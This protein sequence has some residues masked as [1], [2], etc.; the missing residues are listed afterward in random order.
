M[1]TSVEAHATRVGVELLEAG[2]NAIDAAVGV[3]FALAVTHPSAGNIGGGGFMLVRMREQRTVAVDFRE[4]APQGLTQPKFDQMIRERARGPAASG[5]PG[6]VSGLLRAHERWGRLDRARVLAPAIRLAREGHVLG[7]RQGL[8]L[9]WAWP[10]L[11]R[12]ASAAAIFG[13]NGRALRR[14]ER[15]VQADLAKTLQRIAEQGSDGFYRGPTAAAFE[16]LAHRGGMLRSADLAG[17]QA[18]WREPLVTNYRGYTVEVMSP[19]SAGGV[20]VVQMLAMLQAEDAHRWEAGSVQA[21]HWFAEVAKRAHAER[22][23]HV[24]DPDSVERYDT[25]ARLET[26]R[27]PQRWLGPFPISA[28]RVTAASDLHPLYEAAMAELDNTTHFSV[29]DAEGNAVSCT[30]TL[31]GSFGAKYVL[32]GTGVVMNNSVGAFGTVGEDVPKPGRRMTSSMSPTLLLEG[33]RLVALLGSP[34]GD[35][36]PNTVVQVLTNL[37]DHSM[38]LAQAIAAPRVHHGFVPDAIRYERLR[39]P[40]AST[41]QALRRLGHHLAP[42]RRTIGD[43]NNILLTP[44][45]FMLGVADAREGGLA[46]GP[47]SDSDSTAP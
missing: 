25:K 9:G 18:K 14:G 3:A 24:V 16:K 37:V 29:V 32:P 23:F 20:A 7:E 5:V 17:Y 2:G 1:V 19:P 28:E 47:I 31:S 30:T 39:P 45:G 10:L 13:R 36:I 43:A 35:T 40:D 38:P 22:R 11:R 26:W 46:L 42:P 12:D 33:Q 44:D 15:L 34:G 41:L 8:V 21:L 27:S 4:Q 6:S